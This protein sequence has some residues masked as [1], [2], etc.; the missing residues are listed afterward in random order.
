MENILWTHL[1]SVVSI[2]M[3]SGTRQLSR[4]S[5]RFATFALE[6]AHISDMFIYLH[7][8]GTLWQYDVRPM[9]DKWAKKRP[10]QNGAVSPH[11]PKS[12]IDQ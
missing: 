8:N 9:T 3:A 11:S 7:C 2:P 5:W 10:K 6:M 12:S 1:S 4:V